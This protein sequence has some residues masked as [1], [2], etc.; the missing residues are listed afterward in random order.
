MIMH[1]VKLFMIVF[2]LIFQA[3]FSIEI[4]VSTNWLLQQTDW[5]WSSYNKM[6]ESEKIA[7][8]EK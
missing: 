2:A 5:K 8:S 4:S 3:P 6:V 1:S 7:E